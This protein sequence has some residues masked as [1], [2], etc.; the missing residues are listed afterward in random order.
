ML[1]E[2]GDRGLAW[3]NLWL[4]HLR[5][6]THLVSCKSTSASGHFGEIVANKSYHNSWNNVYT[7]SLLRSFK[8]VRFQSNS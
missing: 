6:G 1:I 5:H 4:S 3:L 2:A 7:F 8:Y